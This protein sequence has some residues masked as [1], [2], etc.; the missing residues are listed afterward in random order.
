MKILQS[1]IF[2]ALITIVVGV[3]LLKY[4]EETMHW[5]TIVIGLLFFISGLLSVCFYLYEK[6]R[7]KKATPLFDAQGNEVGHRTP[8]FPF[9]GFGSM[10]L[11]LILAM[12][13][14]TFVLGVTY[15]LA[16]ILILG[17]INQLI[18]VGIARSMEPVP[19]IYWLLPLVTLG[20]GIFVIVRPME[21]ATLPLLIIGC[22]MIYYGIIECVNAVLLHVRRK[23]HLQLEQA[24]TVEGT[25]IEDANMENTNSDTDIE[26]AEIIDE[27][28]L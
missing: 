21:V 17:G 4:R 28:A 9:V 3:L 16:A 23:K 6:Q 10:I 8:T 25:P 12:M 20:I 26:D 13:S 27:D 5:L 2:R 1:S 14:T 24:N 19:W 7:L 11:G 22:G 15:T 18:N